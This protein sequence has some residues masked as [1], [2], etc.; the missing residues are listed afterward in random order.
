MAES[1]IPDFDILVLGG[2]LVGCSLACAL[3]G[4]DL[5][6][7]LLEAREPAP[8]P[9][10]FDERRLALAAASIN[11]L[12]VLGVL[13]LLDAPPS[14]LRRIHVSRSG[15]FGSVRLEAAEFG[16]EAFGAVVSARS[17][18]LALEQRLASL[19]D[20]TVLRPCEV[21]ALGQDEGGIWLD[22]MHAGEGKRLRARLLVA[23]D[24]TRSFARE[25]LGIGIEEHD[26][27]QTLFVSALS[28]ERAADGSAWE[29]FGEQGPVALLPMGR[30]YGA[31]CTVRNAEAP[32]VAAMGDE[33][34]RDYFQQRFGWRAG[35]IT[36]VGKRSAHAI[37]R[38][39]AE[40][41][42]QGRALLVGNA[43]QTIH[44]VGAQGFNLGLRD[45]LALAQRI[46]P[47]ADPGAAA[48]LSDYVEARRE[49]R[50]RTLA[51]SD[52]LARVTAN[53]SEPLRALR[54]LG[55]FALGNLPGLAAPLV[56]GAM[57]M[58]GDVPALARGRQ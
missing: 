41:L 25:Q 1:N 35:R 31:I 7:G 20:T 43:A 13:A 14:P 26:Y 19:A 16:R 54:S 58:R 10:G 29:R 33:E 11:A 24:G 47:G 40:R 57:G 21:R 39:L 17:L 22:A 32:H 9:A 51:F 46:T 18:G 49:D 52:G 2:G 42:V 27:G 36:R 12:D 55:L 38:V 30:D 6:V 48:L 3:E 44:P 56:A 8:M 34:Y 4:K 37:V 53:A 23:A 28:A 50:E 5:R 15:D 45:A